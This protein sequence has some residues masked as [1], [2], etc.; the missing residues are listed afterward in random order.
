LAVLL[1]S[2]GEAL[3]LSRA[4][5]EGGVVAPAIRPPTV[6][7]GTSRIRL[8]PMATQSFDDIDSALAVF[9][10]ADNR[11]RERKAQ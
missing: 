9:P 10:P 3:R 6:P 7:P 2:P 1:G 8:S 5:E 4:L 11:R